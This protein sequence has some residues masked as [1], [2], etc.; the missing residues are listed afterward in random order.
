MAALAERMRRRDL[1]HGELDGFLIIGV[2][3][4]LAF[5]A[6][7]HMPRASASSSGPSG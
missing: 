2:V 4:T 5:L 6:A 1:L 3:A 7:S